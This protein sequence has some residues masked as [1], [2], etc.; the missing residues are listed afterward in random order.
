[1]PEHWGWPIRLRISAVTVVPMPLEPWDYL[2]PEA[3]LPMQLRLMT[4]GVVSGVAS[5]HDEGLMS[6]KLQQRL[7]SPGV[8]RTVAARGRC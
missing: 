5:L 6:Y 7:P 1:M 3:M 8:A 2:F 4:G